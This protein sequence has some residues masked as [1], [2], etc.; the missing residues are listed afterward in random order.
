MRTTRKHGLSHTP[1]YRAWQTMRL[2]CTNPDNA[3][4]ANYGGRGITVCARWMEDPAAF[5]ADMGKKPSPLHEIDRIDNDGPYSPE[6]CRWV[7]R[8]VNDRNRRSNRSI[9]HAGETLTVAEWA[10]RTGL[11]ATVILHRLNAGWSAELALT[12]PPRAK[13]PKGLGKETLRHP[14]QDCGAPIR[15]QSLRCKTCSNRQKL[16]SIRKKTKSAQVC[17]CGN[18]VDPMMAVRRVA[19]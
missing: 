12:T 10:E 11:S 13:A 15:V 5:L 8:K 4:W 6:N 1:E 18:S 7:L 14:C 19:A 2:R 16:N 3:A 9:T 17:M